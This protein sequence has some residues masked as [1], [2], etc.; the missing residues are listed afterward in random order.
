MKSLLEHALA[1]ARRGWHIYRCWPATNNPSISSNGNKSAT[2][3]EEQ[4]RRW[5]T[6]KPD[7]NPGVRLDR[8]G[9]VVI[10]VDRHPDV[11]DG[12]ESLARL[13]SANGKLPLTL[14]ATTPRHGEH[15]YFQIPA[16]IIVPQ[17]DKRTNPG[18]DLL[19]NGGSCLP[20]SYRDELKDGEQITGYY[21]WID[22]TVPVAPFPLNWVAGVGTLADSIATIRENIPEDA[23]LDVGDRNGALYRLGCAL[24]RH[25][26]TE[27]RIYEALA[28]ENEARCNPPLPDAEVRSI[29]RSTMRHNP[30]EKNQN[31]AQKSANTPT[32]RAWEAPKP[33]QAGLHRVP[34]LDV[35]ATL[36]PLAAQ[37][38]REITRPMFSPIEFAVVPLLTALGGCLGNAVVVQPKQNDDRWRVVPNLFGCVVGKPGATKTPVAQATLAPLYTIAAEWSKEHQERLADYEAK[39]ADYESAMDRWKA[40]CKSARKDGGQ[41]PPKPTHP[42][43]PP[44]E[45]RI[46]TGFASTEKMIELAQQNPDGLICMSDEI[47]GW[48]ASMTM[49]GHDMER[50]FWLSGWDGNSPYDYD[51]KS[52]GH[53]HVDHLTLSVIG[54]IQPGK[55]RGILQ[56]IIDD[57]TQN[58][59]LMERLQLFAWPDPITEWEY[60]D[61][62]PDALLAMKVEA[63]FSEVLSLRNS[64]DSPRTLRFDSDAQAISSRG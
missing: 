16:G 38:C 51:T 27:D 37:W 15:R 47:A 21:Q 34:P 10:D 29:A 23:P 58:D 31:G 42:G 28:M 61:E 49:A 20:P 2:T 59:G 46:T 30:A 54:G 52:G 26:S 44:I 62:R 6:E 1:Y 60:V 4:I 5:W 63:L 53:Q 17:I 48:L 9:L 50:T 8:S 57:P 41:D 64:L 55:L 18:I 45:P 12:F 35:D 19:W 32:L 22:E 36:P 40:D 43:D 25:G 56:S 33:I 13:E 3:D 24:R 14:T 7:C 11:P 39:L